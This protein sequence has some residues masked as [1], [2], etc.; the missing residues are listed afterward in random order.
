MG[1]V[2]KQL[3]SSYGFESPYFIVDNA[4]NL[5]TQTVTVTGSRIELTAGSYISY[6]GVPLLTQT[7]LGSS[8]T[9]IPGVLTGLSVGGTLAVTGNLNLTGGTLIST[10]KPALQGSIDN[11]TIGLNTPAAGTFSNLTVSG[12]NSTASISPSGLATIAP[13]G[14]LTL[15]TSSVQTNMVGNITVTSQQNITISP[16]AVTV[17]GV[18]SPN[19]GIVTINPQAVGT[20]DNM[21]IGS[22]TPV[23][24]FFTQVTHTAPDETWNG[25]QRSYGSTKRY[26]EKIAIAMSFFSMGQ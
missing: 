6:S 1:N 20:I 2:V 10:I 7:S 9:S 12:T 5:I 22:K 11:M 16:T 14:V 25:F 21:I 17:N 23:A 8:V 13:L 3:R 15:G 24:S 4:G 18:I 26:T 19:T